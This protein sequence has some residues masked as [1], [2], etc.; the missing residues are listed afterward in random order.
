MSYTEIF[1]FKKKWRGIKIGSK[2]GVFGKD[3]YVL[4]QRD[5]QIGDSLTLIYG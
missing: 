3:E 2:T 5:K 1:K 4:L